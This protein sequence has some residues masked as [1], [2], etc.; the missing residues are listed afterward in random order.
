[1]SQGFQGSSEVMS[2]IAGVIS[3]DTSEVINYYC[4]CNKQ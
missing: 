2:F 1:M 4:R 3:N